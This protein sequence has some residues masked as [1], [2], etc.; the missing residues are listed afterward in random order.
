VFFLR[1]EIEVSRNDGNVV[2][3][4]DDEYSGGGGF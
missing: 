4:Q 2:E 1:H 3:P